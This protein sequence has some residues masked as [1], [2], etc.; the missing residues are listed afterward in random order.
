MF[1]IEWHWEEIDPP[2]EMTV[3]FHIFFLEF[4]VFFFSWRENCNSNHNAKKHN[5]ISGTVP[6]K[7]ESESKLFVIY[8]KQICCT[9]ESCAQDRF[10]L[11]CCL[12]TFEPIK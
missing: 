1:N 2:F 7:D 3:W 12:E 10:V 4:L 6:Q 11:L 8:R 9:C 5:T